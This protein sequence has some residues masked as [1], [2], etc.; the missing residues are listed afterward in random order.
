MIGIEAMRRRHRALGSCRQIK[1]PIEQETI[2]T[3][4]RLFPGERV[5]FGSTAAMPG[6]KP[7]LILRLLRE[8]ALDNP[9]WSAPARG[10]ALTLKKSAIGRPYL[11][12][13]NQKEGP[14]LSFSHGGGRLWAAMCGNG[15]VGIDVAYPEEFRGEYPFARAFRPEEQDY[16]RALLPHDEVRGAALI[17]SLKE[18]SS[19]AVGSGFNLF[20]PLEVCVRTSLFR[21]EGLLFEVL[22]GSIPVLAWAREEGEGWLSVARV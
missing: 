18:A 14:S 13:G 12:L 3:L 17:W 5:V 8:L 15:S 1:D 9:D 7:A 16:A 4:P 22:A 10:E 21:E 11:L 20:D 2:H 6:A 19:K